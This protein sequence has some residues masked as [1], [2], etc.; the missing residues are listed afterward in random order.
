MPVAGTP[1]IKE[2]CEDA[3]PFILWGPLLVPPDLEPSLLLVTSEEQTGFLGL[4]PRR[5][6]VGFA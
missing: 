1:D 3:P 4:L 6:V 2:C 5:L